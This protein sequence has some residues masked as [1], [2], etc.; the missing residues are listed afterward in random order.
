MPKISPITASDWMIFYAS[1]L[2]DAVILRPEVVFSNIT[3]SLPVLSVVHLEH[4]DGVL[5]FVVAS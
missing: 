5:S 2:L 1:P 3:S 4:S